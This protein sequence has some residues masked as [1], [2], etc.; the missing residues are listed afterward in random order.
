MT[1]KNKIFLGFVPVIILMFVLGVYGFFANRHVASMFV[2]HSFNEMKYGNAITSLRISIMEMV[3]STEE[4]DAGWVSREEMVREAEEQKENINSNFDILSASQA[5]S[6]DVAK[7]RTLVTELYALNGKLVEKHEEG[8]DVREG[9]MQEFDN[10]TAEL[11]LG[12]DAM[13]GL[14]DEVM[15]SRME[16]IRS[17]S[18]A[19]TVISMLLILFCLLAASLS[20]YLI[21]AAISKPIKSLMEAALNVARGNY[22]TELA[23]DSEDEVGGLARAFK[24]M[25]ESIKGSRA[26]VEAK[27]KELEK[28]NKELED[29]LDDFYTLRIGMTRDM[30]KGVLEAENRKIKSK[31]NKLRR[32]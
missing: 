31:I 6:A 10:K 23:I 3:R 28:K 30:E 17:D 2:E 21:S 7:Q 22:E 18:N 12:F 9:I 8:A 24:T 11:K 19:F 32:T 20:G 15:N 13:S 27:A 25:A 1:I 5:L 4:Y 14:N 16:N 26:Q 29:T